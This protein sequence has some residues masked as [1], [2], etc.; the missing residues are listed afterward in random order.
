M[1][2]L[3]L[4]V[5]ER[6]HARLCVRREEQEHGKREG[7]GAEGKEIVLATKGVQRKSKPGTCLYE[8]GVYGR[9]GGWM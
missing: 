4:K 8:V 2:L 6:A 3:D 7:P 5:K 1:A 9:L